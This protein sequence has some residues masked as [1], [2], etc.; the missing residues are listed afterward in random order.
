MCRKAWKQNQSG[1][2][3]G[4]QQISRS[5]TGSQGGELLAG[6]EHQVGRASGHRPVKPRVSV[7]LGTRLQLGRNLGRL[8]LRSRDLSPAGE[9]AELFLLEVMSC[10]LIF[11]L[12]GLF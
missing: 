10:L 1:S 5:V 6:T 7:P 3:T 9:A 4:H 2:A 12:L 11:F 8:S